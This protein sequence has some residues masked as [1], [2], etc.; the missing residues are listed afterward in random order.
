LSDFSLLI[1]KTHNDSNDIA[2]WDTSML[3]QLMPILL[4]NALVSLGYIF[5]NFYFWNLLNGYLTIN[6]WNPFQIAIAHVIVTS[7]GQTAPA[8]TYFPLPNYP[9]ILFWVSLVG[10]LCFFIL[11]LRNKEKKKD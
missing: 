10:N 6:D 11:A 2:E 7:N 4:F 5:S 3:K 9:F 8:G 1:P